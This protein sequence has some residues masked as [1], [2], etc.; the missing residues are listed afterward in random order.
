MGL[1]GLIGWQELMM[2]RKVMMMMMMMMMTG[3][4]REYSIECLEGQGKDLMAG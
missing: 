4:L 1:M 3:N 2:V